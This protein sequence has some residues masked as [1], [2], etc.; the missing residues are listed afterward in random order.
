MTA[1]HVLE[2][3]QTLRSMP[4]SKGVR[5]H[6]ALAEPHAAPG[7]PGHAGGLPL[8]LG[9]LDAALP[10]GGL[11]RGGVVEL[12][13]RGAGACA[14]SIALAACGAAQREAQ[15]L[16]GDTPW[17][18]FIDP[19]RSLHAPGV[20]RAGVEL[21]RLLVVRPELADLERIALR[22]VESQVFAVVAID[23][24]GVTGRSL[25]VPLAG[26]PRVIRRLSQAIEGT[27]RCVLLI[28][29]AAARRPL[30]L[31]VAM[32]LELGRPR[33]DRLQVQVAKDR[34]GRVGSP[35][36][37]AWTRPGARAAAAPAP[38]PLQRPA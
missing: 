37:V 22:V 6:L 5:A 14:T 13:V 12:A 18:A 3:L 15:R 21:E 17:C 4:A 38:T 33:P 29:D 26:F 25:S 2:R 8:D 1:A 30:P 35:R 10:D 9:A 36:S 11:L 7:A 28:T 24:I 32:R 23:T 19:S 16:G 27:P 20:R 34:R 31:P